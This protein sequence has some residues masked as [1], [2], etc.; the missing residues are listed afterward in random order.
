MKYIA[1]LLATALCAC[2]ETTE[3]TKNP[4]TRPDVTQWANEATAD[5]LQ[6]VKGI[7]EVI[8]ARII[9]ARPHKDVQSVCAVK[10]IGEV[11]AHRIVEH[12]ETLQ[13]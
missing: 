8:A 7:G 5:Q 9:A 13:D 3:E 12:V 11:I 1:I 2:G 4:D 10:G 6:E